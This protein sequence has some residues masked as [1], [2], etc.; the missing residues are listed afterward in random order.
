MLRTSQIMVNSKRETVKAWERGRPPLLRVA[1]QG[2][3]MRRPA[4]WKAL[5]VQR[6]AGTM[7]WEQGQR[8]HRP[9]GRKELAVFVV[10]IEAHGG[11]DEMRSE[12]E[13]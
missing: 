2:L 9:E 3:H 11:H 4:G 6:A 12:R 7:S 8:A 5:A 10:L 1:C 13:A